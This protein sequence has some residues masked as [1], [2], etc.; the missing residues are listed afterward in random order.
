V[1]LISYPF[2]NTKLL[3]TDPVSSTVFFFAAAS[4]KR[5]LDS[6]SSFF[7]ELNEYVFLPLSLSSSPIDPR[8]DSENFPL[9]VSTRISSN[10]CGSYL[11]SERIPR[12]ISSRFSIRRSLSVKR[13]IMLWVRK[14][15]KVRNLRPQ[16]RRWGR[17]TKESRRGWRGWRG[18]CQGT[19]FRLRWIVSF[20]SCL[21]KRKPRVPL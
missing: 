18:R 14:K 7:S 19:R 13:G 3:E 9:H 21:L 12:R 1:S 2:W 11:Q 5:S 10:S 4:T 20:L 15:T 8:T 6:S 17:T 16:Y